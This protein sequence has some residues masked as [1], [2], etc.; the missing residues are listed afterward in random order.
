MEFFPHEN[1]T[2]VVSVFL[3]AVSE[4]SQKLYL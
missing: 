3:L 4:C 2:E 1:K